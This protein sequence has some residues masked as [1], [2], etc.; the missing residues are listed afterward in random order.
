MTSDELG[1]KWLLQKLYDDG[2]RYCA[3]RYNG[4]LYLT[5][6][7]PMVDMESGYIN[8]YSCNKFEYANC[9][10][11]V[12]P[13]IKGN[14]VLNIAKELG[15]IDWSKVKVDT[16]ILVS[17]NKVDWKPRY[18][19]RYTNGIVETWLCGCTSWSIDSAND[20]C[21]WKYAKLVGDTDE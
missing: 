17:Q 11:S 3:C 5:N 12:F 9:L 2:W 1:K 10:K 7:M 20:T 15:F 6:T 4:E 16:P 19:A 8:I 21:S 18:F 13:K 14:E